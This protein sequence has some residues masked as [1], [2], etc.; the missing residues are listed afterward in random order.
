M[1]ALKS[2]AVSL[3]AAAAAGTFAMIVSPRGSMDKTIR[4]VVGI[5]VVAAIFSPL[6]ELKKDGK[7][8]FEKEAFA[9]EEENEADEMLSD[10]LLTACKN[11]VN[12][13]IEKAADELSIPSYQSEIDAY[14]DD[15]NCII[16]QNI[17]INIPAE[18]I[19]KS[20]KLSVKASERIGAPVTV[21]A[22]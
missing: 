13:E 8:F 19:D 18:Y 10:Y 4:A 12:S 7:N 5:F 14:V 11:A 22:E 3:I 9:F 20:E 6:T 15:D 2:W 1:D 16:I 17:T 21:N